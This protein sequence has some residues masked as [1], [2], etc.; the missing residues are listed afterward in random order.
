MVAILVK[1]QPIRNKSRMGLVFG[2]TLVLLGCGGDRRQ[3]RPVRAL[4]GRS[5]AVVR[6]DGEVVA[7]PREPEVIA[8]ATAEAS[9]GEPFAWPAPSALERGRITSSVLM[10]DPPP[11]YPIPRAGAPVHERFL[12]LVRAGDFLAARE[13]LAGHFRSPAVVPGDLAAF[14][15]TPCA[16]CTHDV[17]AEL[18]RRARRTG[19]RWTEASALLPLLGHPEERVRAAVIEA[20]GLASVSI[21]AEALRRRM[22]YHQRVLR[23]MATDPSPWVRS[24]AVSL[25]GRLGDRVAY[26]LFLLA[27]V[28]EFPVVRGAA[29]QAIGKAIGLPR[30]AE[31]TRAVCARLRDRSPVVRALTLDVVRGTELPCG[32]AP[33]LAAL[34]DSSRVAFRLVTDENGSL[35]ERSLDHASV[36]E[37]AWAALP[38]GLRA[39][40]RPRDPWTV[41]IR[42]ARQLARRLDPTLPKWSDRDHRLRELAPRVLAFPEP[43]VSLAFRAEA[44]ERIVRD[45]APSDQD[46]RRALHD[47]LGQALI[48][49]GLG[50]VG[51]DRLV[52]VVPLLGDVPLRGALLRRVLSLL[53]HPA[54]R[55]RAAALRTL[56]RGTLDD[57]RDLVL[58]RALWLGRRDP[59]PGVRAEALA[60]LVAWNEG[61]AVL[62]RLRRALEDPSAWVRR[63]AVIPSVR[64]GGPEA[65]RVLADRIASEDPSVRAVAIPALVREQSP[66][67]RPHQVVA[68]LAD[69]RSAT[70]S[71]PESA[72]G[73]RG[74]PG[75]GSVRA[76]VLH[77]LEMRFGVRHRG[78]E[79][80][81]VK[82]WQDDLALHGWALPEPPGA[83]E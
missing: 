54:P 13:V 55:V 59:D 76:A 77:A 53:A 44:L 28:D 24:E 35:G 10:A 52:V 25:L 14:G 2:L 79:D 34:G 73:D 39:A 36:R 64:L 5:P 58:R 70:P 46:L 69:R 23:R 60:V 29:A 1:L 37:A 57:R 66:A 61:A 20:L 38:E 80:V 82:R 7:P 63:C 15:L 21:D 33:L 43:P 41:R 75:D 50:R 56:A 8:E 9:E 4:D 6:T 62:E 42:E 51:P 65:H 83:A 68:A 16:P 31:T 22:E 67:L 30:G 71:P 45:T 78:I 17:L 40:T 3:G 12:R 48:A 72:P 27:A 19:W 32:L 11:P 26:R 49:L 74:D 47:P 81:R 18:K